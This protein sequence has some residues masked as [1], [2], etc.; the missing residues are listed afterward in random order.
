MPTRTSPATET[1]YLLPMA[2]VP[3]TSVDDLG[4]PEEF[5]LSQNY[6]NPFNPSTKI[7]FNI[8]K[9][10]PVKGG[11]NNGLL[12]VTIKIYD[13]LGKEVMTLVNEEMRPGENEFEFF[14]NGLSSGVY[15]YKLQAGSF[16]DSKKMILLK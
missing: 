8:P 9:L 6:P 14:A 1:P 10:T 3:V 16:A 12:Y 2:T 13:S 15:Y 7:R 5:S 11:S 4:K